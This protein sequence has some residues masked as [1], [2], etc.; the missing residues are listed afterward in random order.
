MTLI[1]NIFVKPRL[2]YAVEA[3][4]EI[5][6]RQKGGYAKLYDIFAAFWR[7][8]PEK[9]PPK[10]VLP[11]RRE[12]IIRDLLYAHKWFHGR[13]PYTWGSHFKEQG[14]NSIRYGT[15]RSATLRHLDPHIK[16]GVM[17]KAF[18]ERIKNWWN[19]VPLHIRTGPYAVFKKHV[20]EWIEKKE[21]HS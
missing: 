6:T 17:S 13:L 5:D 18:T 4:H 20:T 7:I 2:L 11:P 21:L 9:V 1:Y 10:S 19:D 15:N 3:W 12:M 8:T 14:F 16:A